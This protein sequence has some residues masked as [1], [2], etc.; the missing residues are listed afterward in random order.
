[1]DGIIVLNS[2]C[3][4]RGVADWVGSGEQSDC[5]VIANMKSNN[6][7]MVSGHAKRYIGI[8]H[9]SVMELCDKCDMI[10]KCFC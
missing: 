9:L 6:R 5:C 1:M 8:G 2:E 7:M 3:G 4:A 10:D